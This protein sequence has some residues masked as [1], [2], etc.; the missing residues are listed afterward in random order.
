MA[1]CILRFCSTEACTLLVLWQYF[2]ISWCAGPTDHQIWR[3]HIRVASRPS[4]GAQS[5]FEQ[6]KS[7]DKLKPQLDSL[8]CTPCDQSWHSLLGMGCSNRLHVFSTTPKLWKPPIYMSL[9][10]QSTSAA[11]HAQHIQTHLAG[12]MSNV[13]VRHPACAGWRS[14][15]SLS[16][17][18]WCPT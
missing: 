14:G 16:Q 8:M 9:G 12:S 5:L 10:L 6:A 4:E 13:F 15:P 1:R 18:L 11:D 3:F 7:K 17:K 2:Q